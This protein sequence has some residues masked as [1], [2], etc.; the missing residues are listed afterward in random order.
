[1]SNR[2]EFLTKS[3]GFVGIGI[4]AVVASKVNF[5][6]SKGLGI[7]KSTD[8]QKEGAKAYAT[9]GFGMNCSGGGGQC[10]FGMGCG[11]A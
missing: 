9:C 7:S 8:D 1:M 11:G 6:K 3:L 4:A 10:G 2:R 5:D